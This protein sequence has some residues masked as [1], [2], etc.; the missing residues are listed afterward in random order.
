MEH[1]ICKTCGAQFAQSQE[2]PSECPICR[3]QRQYVGFN[4]QQWTTL[5]QMLA[6]G[7]HNVL[8]EEEP[9]LIGIGTQ[10]SF[11]IG[12]RALLIPGKQGNI[13]WDCISFLDD[14]T[15]EAVRKLG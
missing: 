10:P 7:F 15:V 5:A 4:G 12:Q 1:W 11:A 2:P 3:D 13:L 6:D 9:G 14:E 8:K